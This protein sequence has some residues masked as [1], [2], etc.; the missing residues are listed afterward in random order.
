LDKGITVVASAAPAIYNAWLYPRIEPL[1]E[2]LQVPLPSPKGRQKEVLCLPAEGHHAVL[3]TAGSGKTTL[4]IHRSAFLASATAAHHGPTLLVTFNRT[5]VAYLNHWRNSRLASVT[6]ENYHTFARGYLSS[7][8]L[9][10]N[11]A[12]CRPGQRE[13]LIREVVLAAQRVQGTVGVLARPVEAI[14]E[15]IRW[16]G[17]HGARTLEK[18]RNVGPSDPTLSDPNDQELLFELYRRYLAARKQD[19]KDYDWDDIAAAV[20]EAFDG[21]DSPRRYRHVVIDEGQD[22]S[23][24]MIR[25]LTKAVGKHG[26]VTFFAD[27]A[28]QIYGHRVSWRS[29]GLE[30]S[31]PWLF[32]ENFRNSR[33]IA[34]LALAISEMPYFAGTA[35]LVVPREPAAD[36][37]MPTLVEFGSID[38]EAAFVAKQASLAGRTRTVGVLVRTHQLE[39]VL[40]KQ[41]PKNSVRL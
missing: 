41:L 36:G 14:A 33:Q 15:E 16:I 17:Q 28:Q 8:G 32:E 38:E 40:R 31:E 35:D 20:S 1:G 27:V 26:S 24:E 6:I 29:A 30:I 5:L 34:R 7:R 9:L 25:S 19:G 2:D 10:G 23:P 39:E 12:I 21:D 18:Y 22:F 13:S 3:G 11:Y 37:P 4:A